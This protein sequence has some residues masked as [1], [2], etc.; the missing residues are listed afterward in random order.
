MKTLLILRHA[1]S[2]WDD[3]S[4]SDHERSLNKRGRHAAPRIGELLA[5]EDLLPDCIV[6]STAVRVRETVELVARHAGYHGKIEF[7]PDLYLAGPM[8]YLEVLRQLPEV[9]NSAMAVGHNPG[10]EELLSDLTGAREHLSTASLA[11]VELPI[12]AWAELRSETPGALV[13]L[14]RP[15]ELEE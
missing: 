11:Q 2:S 14:W 5:E 7:R 15:K 3:S 9:C 8:T 12:A 10:L 4:Q 1:K 6:G 13:N